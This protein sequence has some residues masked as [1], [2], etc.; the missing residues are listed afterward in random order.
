M[1]VGNLFSRPKPQPEKPVIMPL[2]TLKVSV[3]KILQGENGQPDKPSHS[4]CVSSSDLSLAET[5]DMQKDL[6]PILISWLDKDDE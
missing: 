5:K 4:V 6:A 1:F 2:Y 3:Q